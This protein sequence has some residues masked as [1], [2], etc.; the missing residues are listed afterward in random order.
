G[1]VQHFVRDAAGKTSDVH[2]VVRID[3]PRVAEVSLG[4]GRIDQQHG[5]TI[6][7]GKHIVGWAKLAQRAPAH[8]NRAAWE[9][10]WCARASARIWWAGGRCAALS[11]ST[12]Y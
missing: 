2:H 10:G 8:Q 7:W 12:C 3:P 11:H 5:N 9:N 6:G 1:D 4:V